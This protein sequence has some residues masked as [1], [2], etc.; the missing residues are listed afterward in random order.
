MQTAP[1]AFKESVGTVTKMYLEGRID[2]LIQQAF[3]LNQVELMFV[4]TLFF[5]I[6]ISLTE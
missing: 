5:K 1:E 2:P 6:V 3:P 4:L